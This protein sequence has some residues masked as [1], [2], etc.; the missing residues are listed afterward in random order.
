MQLGRLEIMDQAA[1]EHVAK[2]SKVENLDKK[3][4][5][6]PDEKYKNLQEEKNKLPKNEVV[7]DNVKFGFDKDSGQFFVRMD[8][9]SM[10]IQFPTEQIMKMKAHFQEAISNLNKG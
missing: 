1:I 8:T 4:T 5:I 6:E 10:E 9:G 3:H 2:I 7:L